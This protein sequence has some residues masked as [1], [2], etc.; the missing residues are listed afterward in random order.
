LRARS[1][2]V[3]NI[4]LKSTSHPITVRKRFRPIGE[5]GFYFCLPSVARADRDEDI[6][7]ESD[8]SDDEDDEQPTGAKRG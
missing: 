5:T 7:N 1:I 3:L 6:S 4:P 2:L 8:I